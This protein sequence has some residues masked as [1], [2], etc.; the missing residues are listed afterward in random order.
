[1]Q[2]VAT[3]QAI[4][5][6]RLENPRIS[7]IVTDSSLRKAECRLRHVVVGLAAGIILGAITLQTALRTRR[8]FIGERP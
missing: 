8:R 6:N 1:M 7:Q 3:A 2:F 5:V 4:T